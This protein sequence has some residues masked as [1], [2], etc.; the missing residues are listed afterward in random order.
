MS[1]QLPAKGHLRNQLMLLTGIITPLVNPNIWCH[2]IFNGLIT[3][4]SE[5]LSQ[6][7]PLG[8]SGLKGPAHNFWILE[9][10]IHCF[11][12]LQQS[13]GFIW[14]KKQTC[15]KHVNSMDL[16]PTFCQQHR[17]GHMASNLG[18]PILMRYC[19]YAP[20]QNLQL[21]TMTTPIPPISHVATS[22]KVAYGNDW[23]SHCNP[24]GAASVWVPGHPF[25]LL[26]ALQWLML[27][28]PPSP[29][30]EA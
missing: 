20:K 18:L 30:L 4:V 11:K 27:V 23:P 25:H 5:V 3:T 26:G 10:W 9:L 17:G 21:A 1:A 29:P 24:H 8:V 13:L 22:S 7:P 2:H 6:V 14:K 16:Q 12:P 19:A 15:A 28:W